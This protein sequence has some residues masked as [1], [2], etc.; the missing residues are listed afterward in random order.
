MIYEEY[1]VVQKAIH[2]DSE[3]YEYLAKKYNTYFYK[4]AFLYLKNEQDSL[5]VVQESIYQG[6]VKIHS[7]RKPEYFVT[8]MNRIVINQAFRCIRKRSNYELY[9]EQAVQ[10]T[11]PDAKLEE[12]IDLYRALKKLRKKERDAIVLKYFY[13][14]PIAEIALILQIPENSVKT[15]LKRAK[16]RL[17]KILKE[18]YFEY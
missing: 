1:S 5:D 2:G 16:E 10:E 3:A 15:I 7:L 11:A 17:K 18:E 6:F 14:K 12:K 4:V 13:D 9:E 8:W